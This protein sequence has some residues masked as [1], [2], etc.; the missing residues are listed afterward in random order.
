[1]KLFLC[2]DVMTGRGIDQILP[3]PVGP[4]LHEPF[5]TSALDY[6]ELAR[7]TGEVIPSRV[8]PPWIWGDALPALEAVAPHLRIANLETSVTE[9]EE[10]APKGIHYRMNPGNVDTLV[11]LGLDA[12][13][14]ANNHVLDRGGSGL[15]ET[16]ET[17]E[18]VGIQTA[19]A[20]RDRDEA[21]APAV[22]PLPVAAGGE[23]GG[24][25]L[26]YAVCTGDS[27]V[28]RSWGA[29]PGRPGVD[30]LP[31][32]SPATVG[33][34]ARRIAA[35]RREGDRVVVSIHWGGNW[36]YAVPRRHRRFAR[37]LVD[38]AGVDLVHGHS[39][40]HPLGAEIHGGRLILYGCGDFLNDY[41]GIPGQEGFRPELVVGW[42]PTLDPGTGRVEALELLPFRI[43][44]FR[45]RTPSD[46]DRAWLL[47]RL[48]R[49]FRPFG[50][51]LGQAGDR[52]VLEVGPGPA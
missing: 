42:L 46:G 7:R 39:S 2:G 44:G 43:R 34:L 8:A 18:R 15:L 50:L 27:G 5:L 13:T 12:C 51:R 41:E 45:L 22:L 19:G 47:R 29:A 21:R 48:R 35:L 32:L 37:A 9:S 40:H 23:G 20:G 3:H 52:F 4:R 11:A 14:L 26:L 36:G 33:E 25:V 30:L 17:L 24:R 31:D 49:E 6:L 1:M 38:E 16:L 10:L 28:P